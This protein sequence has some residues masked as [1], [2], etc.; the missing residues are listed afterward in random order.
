MERF[1]SKAAV[2]EENE[3]WIWTG[4]INNGGYGRFSINSKSVGAHR[5]AYELTNGPIPPGHDIRHGCDNRKCVN[6]SHLSTGTRQQN[7]DD[8]FS[9]N[10]QPSRRGEHNG[11]NILNTQLVV[12]LRYAKAMSGCSVQKLASALDMKRITL[13]KAISGENWKWV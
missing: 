4:H 1:W 5:V 12:A 8:M 7:I 3:C 6:P 11:R 2:G 9:R 10:R 13:Q